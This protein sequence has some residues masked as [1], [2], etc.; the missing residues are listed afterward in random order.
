MFQILSKLDAKVSPD[1]F[2][3]CLGFIKYTAEK[4]IH[5]P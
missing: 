2:D 1:T 5:I 4:Q 3:L